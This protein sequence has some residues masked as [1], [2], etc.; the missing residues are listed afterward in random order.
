MRTQC[1]PL[2]T[3]RRCSTWAAEP[4]HAVC[5]PPYPRPCRPPGEGGESVDDVAARTLSLLEQLEAQH[6]GQHFVLVSHGDALSILAAA[7]LGT[8]LGQH[9]QHGLPNC[10]IM[11]IG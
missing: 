7:A 3:A 1:G 11:R 2:S 9:R 6:A 8:P 4:T 10:G 5:R